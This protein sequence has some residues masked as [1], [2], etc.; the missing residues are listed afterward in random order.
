MNLPVFG[1]EYESHSGFHHDDRIPTHPDAAS[2]HVGRSA[3]PCVAMARLVARMY[4]TLLAS[5][6]KLGKTTL[7]N[8]LLQCF[9]D[10]KPFLGREVKPAKVLVVS[11]DPI[12]LWQA[13]RRI[14][15]VESNVELLAQ[16]FERRPSDLQWSELNR[17]LYDR[18][19]REGF[20]LVVFD[21]LSA[22]L[23]VD[24]IMY[25]EKACRVL[26]PLL[27]LPFT[28]AGILALVN[29]RVPNETL[30]L[31]MSNPHEPSNP[32]RLWLSQRNYGGFGTNPTWR[33]IVNRSYHVATPPTL[34]YSWNPVT[35]RFRA[36]DDPVSERMRLHRAIIVQILKEH[37]EPLT[38]EEILFNWP[39]EK[40]PTRKH[41]DEFLHRA[42]AQ[43]RIRREGKGVKGDPY[44]FLLANPD[45]DCWD[46][47]D[48]ADAGMVNPPKLML[49]AIKPALDE[50]PVRMGV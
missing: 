24:P 34:G 50:E 32:F 16:P 2:D 44:R 30:K 8:G 12:D 1:N 6:G 20:Q 42:V 26:A 3:G 19:T 11:E 48:V 21:S 47:F 15:P 37:P 27:K 33:R 23:P 45:D 41:I 28:G 4:A 22:F 18:V 13:R 43:H 36:V 14:L 7:L 29:T 38:V 39:D 10:G 9:A 35:G 46:G 5:D 31:V 40:V 49:P 25:R 17:Y